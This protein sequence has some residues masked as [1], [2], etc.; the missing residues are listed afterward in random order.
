MK[1]KIVVFFALIG[2]SNIYSQKFEK[3]ALTPPMGWNSW[4]RFGC[5]I[6]EK[7]IKEIA[8]TLVS[9]GMKETGYI[10]INID[11]CWQ[12]NR[13]SLG[14]IYPDPER[15]PSGMKDLVDYVHSKGLK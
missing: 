15:F 11:D 14:F 4:N 13:D 9:S 12:G 8:D 3:L 10:Y 1:I 2:F 6:N 7:L 5:N